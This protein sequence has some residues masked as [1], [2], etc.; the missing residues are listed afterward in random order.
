M[1]ERVPNDVGREISLVLLGWQV[2]REGDEESVAAA[3][4]HAI[5]LYAEETEG[6]ATVKRDAVRD[7]LQRRLSALD[8]PKRAMGTIVFDEGVE[9]RAYPEAEDR[10]EIEVAPGIR[11]GAI[12]HNYKTRRWRY[13]DML[14]T[15]L[16][17][18]GNPDF[19]TDIEAADRIQEFLPPLSEVHA[20]IMSIIEAR[21]N[22]PGEEDTP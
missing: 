22:S 18:R 20:F 15:T 6:I 16:G 21:K 14:R 17:I 2:A 10:T 3:I 7:A 1:L 19:P 4:V 5:R 11:P 12:V 8:N 9:M 13:D